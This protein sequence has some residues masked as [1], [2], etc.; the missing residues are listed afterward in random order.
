MSDSET[1]RQ[2]GLQDSEI[3]ENKRR[4]GLFSQPISTAIGD[5]GAY[6]TR[7]RNFSS[8]PRPKRGRRQRKTYYKAKKLPIWPMS[9][10]AVKKIIFWRFKFVSQF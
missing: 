1:L 6:K 4:F 3:Y 7:F 8:Y 9:I 2:K 5:D 10:W